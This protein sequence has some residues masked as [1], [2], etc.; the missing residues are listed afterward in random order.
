MVLIR[1]GVMMVWCSHEVVFCCITIYLRNL[2]LYPI[3][4]ISMR[5]VS[6]VSVCSGWL[7][8][9]LPFAGTTLTLQPENA[10]PKHPHA[11]QR[12]AP[13]KADAAVICKTLTRKP[14]CPEKARASMQGERPGLDDG[15]SFSECHPENDLILAILVHAASSLNIREKLTRALLSDVFRWSSTFS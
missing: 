3:P 8:D 5:M 4:V 1:M 11:I 10:R 15:R 12:T 9:V 6:F 7:S 13:R 14:L 2:D